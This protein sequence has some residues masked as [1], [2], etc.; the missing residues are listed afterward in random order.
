MEREHMNL[1]ISKKIMTDFVMNDNK[2][3]FSV[4]SG[5]HDSLSRGKYKEVT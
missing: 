1:I 5:E 2:E 3:L 4:S